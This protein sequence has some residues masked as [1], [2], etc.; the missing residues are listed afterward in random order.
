MTKKMMTEA[1]VLVRRFAKDMAELGEHVASY[2]Y[3]TEGVLEMLDEEER[4][5]VRE[6]VNDL[7]LSFYI[8]DIEDDEEL[9]LE[10]ISIAERY[11]DEGNEWTDDLEAE[12]KGVMSA[13]VS[14]NTSREMGEEHIRKAHSEI[15]GAMYEPQFKKILETILAGVYAEG[16]ADGSL[17]ASRGEW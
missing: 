6:S 2:I 1:D 11:L 14:N 7:L 16:F 3:P 17:H 4:D 12:V 10:L 8:N 9:L 5:D 15:I 13:L